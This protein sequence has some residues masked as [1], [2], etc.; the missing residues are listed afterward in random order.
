MWHWGSGSCQGSLPVLSPKD[1]TS[2]SDFLF[3]PTQVENGPSEFALYI[4]H[5][6]GGKC[7]PVL[8]YHKHQSLC[9]CGKLTDHAPFFTATVNAPPDPNPGTLSAPYRILPKTQGKPL[10]LISF[11]W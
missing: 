7:L 5:E 3:L 10:S 4:V 9:P 2:W 8:P 11:S 6:S 1:L